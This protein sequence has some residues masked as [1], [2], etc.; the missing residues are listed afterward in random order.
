MRKLN[1]VLTAV[2]LLL[3][4]MH[5]ILGGFVMIGLGDTALKSVAWITF[6]LILVHVVI[7]AK[8]TADSLRVWKKTG[9][10]YFRENSLFWARRI[11]GFAIMVLLCFHMGAFGY[12]EGGVFRLR[13]FTGFRLATQL[14]LAA[15]IALHVLSNVKPLLI[16]FGIRALKSRAAEILFVLSVVMVFLAAAFIVYY[17]RWNSL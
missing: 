6:A 4:L 12:S 11:S 17:F 16:S 7:S 5:A 13:P 8:Y 10:G 14:L 1:A 3:F 9:V 15:A 2:I